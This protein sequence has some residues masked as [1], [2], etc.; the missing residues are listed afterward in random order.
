[1]QLSKKAEGFSYQSFAQHN[2][3]MIPQVSNLSDE[4]IRDIEIVSQVLPF[5]SNNYVVDQLINWNKVP[6]DPIYTLTFPRKEM[7]TDE[8]YQL[9]RKTMD[10][11]ASKDEI[12]KVAHAIRLQLNPHPAGQLE[13]NVPMIDDHKLPVCNISTGKRFCFFQVRGKPVMPIAA[14][15]FGGHSL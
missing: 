14:F 7:L 13:H 3:R 12:K 15:V 4:Q 8:H 1:M 2:F 9:M 6:D 5:K 11:G 10:A